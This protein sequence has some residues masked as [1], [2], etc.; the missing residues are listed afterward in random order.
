LYKRKT[1]AFGR[2]QA[3]DKSPQC[4]VGWSPLRDWQS[5]TKK[6]AADVAIYIGSMEIGCE[7]DKMKESNKMVN[8][9][10]CCNDIRQLF[11]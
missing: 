4:P 5:L 10:F 9:Y 3:K 2:V 7:N 8:A 11:L 1:L 6:D